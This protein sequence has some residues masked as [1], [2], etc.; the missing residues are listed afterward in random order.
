MFKLE[1][2]I[3]AFFF[4][5]LFFPSRAVLALVYFVLSGLFGSG[6]VLGQKPRQRRNSGIGKFG[7]IHMFSTFVLSSPYTTRT[8][9]AETTFVDVE[10]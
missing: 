3:R 4:L 2:S 1:R 6:P 7:V 10:E 9:E 5:F 8:R